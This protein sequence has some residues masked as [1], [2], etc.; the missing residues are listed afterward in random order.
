MWH[1]RTARVSDGDY[2]HSARSL[3]WL[4][5][6]PERRR[7]RN[8][9]VST[10]FASP[11]AP[12]LRHCSCTPANDAKWLAGSSKP[13]RESCAGRTASSKTWKSSS[14]T[15]LSGLCSCSSVSLLR[16]VQRRSRLTVMR[17]QTKRFVR[18]RVATLLGLRL[19]CT[20]TFATTIW[21]RESARPPTRASARE[22]PSSCVCRIWDV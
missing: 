1:Y 14:S 13:E 6:A 15:A 7:I 11:M 20:S 3:C 19:G 17:K 10:R 8:C 22:L 12:R 2:F 16:A 4:P 18:S 9:W 21:R 5:S